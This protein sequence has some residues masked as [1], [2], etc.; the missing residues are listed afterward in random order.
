VHRLWPGLVRVCDQQI[1]LDGA[2]QLDT[3]RLVDHALAL[4]RPSG[5]GPSDACQGEGR[6][7]VDRGGPE[8]LEVLA[9]AELLPGWY[10]EWVV[11]ERE[12][13]RQLRMHA[14]EELAVRLADRRQFAL[15]MEAALQA[16]RIEPLRESAHRVVIGVHLAEG[17]LVEARRHY[18]KVR[19]LLRDELNVEPTAG[20]HALV[21]GRGWL[22]GGVAQVAPSRR[23]TEGVR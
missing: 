1:A 6:A 7:D 12:R 5:H 18:R 13:L 11:F 9:G 19:R 10:D 14:L 4:I 3:R 21:D 15:A 23:W 20:L 17:N 22:A 2:L 8:A 16:V